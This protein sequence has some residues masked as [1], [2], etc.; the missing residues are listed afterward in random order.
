M[1]GADA[2]GVEAVG[3][4]PLARLE[5]GFAGTAESRCSSESLEALRC[6][7]PALRAL[8]LLELMA[9]ARAGAV[10]LRGPGELLITIDCTPW[11]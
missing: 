5:L 2:A 1:L 8:P 7:N 11:T 4:Q 6:A 10:T 9:A 3:T